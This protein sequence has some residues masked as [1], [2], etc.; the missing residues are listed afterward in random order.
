MKYN[1]LFLLKKN[2]SLKK[3]IRPIYRAVN[4]INNLILIKKIRYQLLNRGL[5]FFF[6]LRKRTCLLAGL[7]DLNHVIY[8]ELK[9]ML[10]SSIPSIEKN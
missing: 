8:F 2:S 3:E 10:R 4:L 9:H 6:F 5:V 1:E 7:K